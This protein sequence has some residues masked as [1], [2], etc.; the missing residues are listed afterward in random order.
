V[1]GVEV[2]AADCRRRQYSSSPPLSIV[3][4]CCTASRLSCLVPLSLLVLPA[5]ATCGIKIAV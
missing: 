3:L 1:L 4:L 5:P 2:V